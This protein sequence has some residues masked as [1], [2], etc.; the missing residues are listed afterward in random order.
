MLIRVKKLRS[1]RWGIRPLGGQFLGLDVGTCRAALLQGVRFGTST[2]T[3]DV[4]ATWGTKIK[5]FAVGTGLEVGL[6]PADMEYP[7]LEFE[8]FFGGDV[9]PPREV[10]HQGNIYTGAGFFP[11]DESHPLFQTGPTLD[12]GG[13]LNY[14]KRALVTEYGVY[15]TPSDIQSHSLVDLKPIIFSLDQ[16]GQRDPQPQT[17]P[18]PEIK[19]AGGWLNKF[20][21]GNHVG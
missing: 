4:L 2:I 21:G 5:S 8:A 6:C 19:P 3:G 7:E 10:C 20:L 17:L 16:L 14:V 1:K 11:C 12:V 15:F 13:S 18:E 9:H